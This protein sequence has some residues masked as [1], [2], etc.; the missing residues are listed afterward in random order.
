MKYN[1]IKNVWQPSVPSR[2]TLPKGLSSVVSPIQNISQ[3]N[4]L[5]SATGTLKAMQPPAALLMNDRY[6]VAH[7]R[8]PADETSVNMITVC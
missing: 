8:V 2:K 6:D 5:N 1:A 4:N 3:K 7:P